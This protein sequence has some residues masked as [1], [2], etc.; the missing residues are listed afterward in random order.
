KKRKMSDI[1]YASEFT[2]QAELIVPT[3]A[4]EIALTEMSSSCRR[5]SRD[6]PSGRFGM[7]LFASNS[8]CKFVRR[9]QNS[10]GISAILLKDKSNKKKSNRMSIGKRSRKTI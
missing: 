3:G 2:P 4:L 10:F 8:C 7:E 9:I 1:T 6:S 5:D